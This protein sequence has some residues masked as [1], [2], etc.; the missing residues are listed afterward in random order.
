MTV[1]FSVSRAVEIQPIHHPRRNDVLAVLVTAALLAAYFLS[2]DVLLL[3][4]A[5]VL[6]SMYVL[7]VRRTHA[8]PAHGTTDLHKYHAQ[9][10]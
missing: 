5:L 4:A 9:N 10:P 1:L 2:G 8:I 7:Y 3:V 6:A